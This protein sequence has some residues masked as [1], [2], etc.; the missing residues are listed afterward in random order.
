MQID[1]IDDRELAKTL[2][3]DIDG[4]ARLVN[5]L[6]EFAELETS[7]VGPEESAELGAIA[8]DT[9]A[10]VAPLAL[11]RAKTVGLVGADRP[12]WVRGD[13]DAL[14]RALLNL[15][16]NALAHTAPGTTVEIAVD[17]AGALHVLDHGPGVPPAERDRIFRRFWRRD[18]R[19]PGHA[20]LGLAIVARIAE[21]HGA[22][23]TVADRPGGGAIF[24]LRFPGVIAAQ[25]EALP[26][27]E[28][29][30]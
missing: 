12:V 27:R 1:T 7:V 2:R 14:G 6:L 16:E 19:R 25:R 3:S 10:A 15:V 4:M 23:V 26:E 8:A 9:V 28:P 17:A 18:R 11:S 22:T 13:R 29:A 24:S 5:Q 30:V 21:M 20:G